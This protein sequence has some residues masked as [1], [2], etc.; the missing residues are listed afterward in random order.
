[1]VSLRG[2]VAVVSGAG[3]GIGRVIAEALAAEGMSL[4]LIARTGPQVRV[5]A[6]ELTD[7]YGVPCFPVAADITDTAA[8]ERMVMHVEQHLGAVDLLVN[9]AAIIESREVPFWQADLDEV[10]RVVEVNLRGPMV[11]TRAL[12][13]AMVDRG[14]GHVVTVASLARAATQTGTYTG[15]AVSKRALSIFTGSLAAA[16][17]GTGVIVVDVLPGLVRTDLTAGMPTWRDVTDWDDPAATAST[18]VEIARGRYDDAA[19]STLD[20][21]ATP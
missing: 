20:A 5:A 4:A 15:Y 1:M 7:R 10:W 2:R 6:E 17:Q 9:D 19:G 21:S 3:R 18:V 11:L 13:P 14:R 16:L 12:L 8:V